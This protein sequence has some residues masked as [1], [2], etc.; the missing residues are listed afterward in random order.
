MAKKLTKKEG[1]VNGVIVK[2]NE[3]SKGT[4]K[5]IYFKCGAGGNLGNACYDLVKGEFIKVHGQVGPVF[6]EGIEK[7]FLG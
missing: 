2:A 1:I 4:A 6:K 5:R 7:E 3:W